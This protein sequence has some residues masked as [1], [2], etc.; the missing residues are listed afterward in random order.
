MTD[1]IL[2]PIDR[3]ILNRIQKDFP[4]TSK[5]YLQIANNLNISENEVIDRIK[6]LKTK[7]LIRR[8]GGVFASRKLGYTSTL[9]AIK[10]PE[11]RVQEVADIIN[12]YEGVTH[13]YLRNHIYNLWFTYI[14]PSEDNILSTLDEIKVK[15]KINDIINLPAKEL[16]KINVNFHLKENT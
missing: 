12:S 16:F 3:D 9:C 1:H 15:T 7:G 14:A 10:V 11:N 6:E 13:N 4:V 2:D 8:L 5:P